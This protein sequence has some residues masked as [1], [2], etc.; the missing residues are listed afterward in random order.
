MCVLLGHERDVYCVSFSPDGRVVASGSM[1]KTVRL[2][3]A[4]TGWELRVLGGH[5]GDVDSVSFSPDG[6]VV[7]SKSRNQTVVWDAQTGEQ[8]VVKHGAADPAAVA[9]GADRF[10]WQAIASQ[11]ETVIERA[12]DGRVIAW[13][14]KSLSDLNLNASGTLWAGSADTQLVF[15]RLEGTR[16][17]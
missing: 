3:D 1:D 4:Q 12:A 13:F 6:R 11:G 7:A 9:T 2:W 15:I 14:P 5:A 17:G 8:L 16:L 10:P